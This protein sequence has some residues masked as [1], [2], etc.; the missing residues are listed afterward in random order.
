MNVDDGSLAMTTFTSYFEYLCLWFLKRMK[1]LFSLYIADRNSKAR[2][3]ILLCA[4]YADDIICL[5][6]LQNL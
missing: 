4:V 1:F 2:I 3:L 6:N 5:E